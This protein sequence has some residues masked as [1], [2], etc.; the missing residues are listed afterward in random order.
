MN[1][2]TDVKQVGNNPFLI[3]G[4][5]YPYV[6]A[7]ENLLFKVTKKDLYQAKIGDPNQCVGA[8]AVRRQYAAAYFRRDTAVILSLG[9]NGEGI[10]R[11]YRL[12]GAIVKQIKSFDAT[13]KF[14]LGIYELKAITPSQTLSNKREA[15]RL[16]AKTERKISK[17]TISFMGRTNTPASF[18]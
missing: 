7:T 8:C 3:N 10:A 9:P 17:R 1:N 5:K 2:K 18:L 13:G 11:R 15:S 16:P 14:D 12:S 4:K 6:D